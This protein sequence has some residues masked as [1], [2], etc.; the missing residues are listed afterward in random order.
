MGRASV[1]PPGMPSEQVDVLW[2]AFAMASGSPELLADAE[3]AKIDIAPAGGERVQDGIRRFTK[4][5]PKSWCRRGAPS[6]I[7]PA[8][9]RLHGVPCPSGAI[10][11]AWRS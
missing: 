8:R 5:L 3:R 10:T 11:R 4:R 7:E 9:R 6:A 2:K 1:V